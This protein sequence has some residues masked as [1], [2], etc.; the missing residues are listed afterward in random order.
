MVDGVQDFLR[1][2]VIDCPQDAGLTLR[3]CEA[4]G[5]ANIGVFETTRGFK[6]QRSRLLGIRAAGQRQ[7]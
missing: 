2:G 7:Q 3:S 1:T 4:T 6:Y 5:F